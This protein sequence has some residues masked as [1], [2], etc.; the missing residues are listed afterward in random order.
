MIMMKTSIRSTGALALALIAT[1][2]VAQEW[3]RFRGPNGSG[4][5]DAATI[6][7]EF[8]EK[9]YNW[10]TELPGIGHSSPVI[11][12]DKVFL[13]SA[14]PDDATRYVLCI[15][16]NS[17]KI[18]WQRDYASKQ[19]HLH[20]R[21]SYASCTPAVDAERVYV[22]WSTPDETLLKAFDH[23]GK[24][25]WSKNLGKWVSQHGWGSS[26]MLYEDLVIVNDSQ[27]GPEVAG[28]DN[29]EP[30]ESF[31]AAFDQKTG[32]LRW[33]TPRV[34]NVV[35]YSVPCIYKGSDG[36]D[37]LICT[38]TGEGFFSLDPRTGEENWRIQDAFEMRTVSS[39]VIIDGLIFG[40]TGQGGFATNYV[41]AMHP[42]PKPEIAYDIRR[43]APYVPCI[44]GRGDLAF[45][46]FDAGIVSCIEAATGD[47]HWR[48]RVG[49]DFSSS[50]IRVGNKIFGVDENGVV[51]VLAA[52]KEFRVLAQNP[53]GEPSRATPAV[54]DGRMYFRTYSHLI[55]LGGKPAAE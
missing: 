20:V 26:P 34:S 37:Q 2:A 38:T 40:S 21:S 23:A 32:D 52:E 18:L 19:H 22:A 36:K 8:T 5:S 50:P 17:G 24:E 33:K 27:D 15:D 9:D 3:T 6:P 39:P 16:V 54:A 35:S 44:V 47:V 51:V 10:K 12:K 1:A 48:E 55:S 7:A 14:N 28:K 25:L 42:E 46:W 11:W 30:G 49:G 13:L 43:Q 41:L 29:K 45:L 31:V 53:L 4:E